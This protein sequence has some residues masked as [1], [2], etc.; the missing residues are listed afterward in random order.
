MIGDADAVKFWLG[1][2]PDKCSVLYYDG[3]NIHD[4]ARDYKHKALHQFLVRRKFQG[5]E[6]LNVY[7]SQLSVS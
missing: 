4:Y 3:R 5:Q 6:Y 2:C 1:Q 7:T